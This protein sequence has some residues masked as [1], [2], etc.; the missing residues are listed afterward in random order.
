MATIQG[1]TEKT[2]FSEEE[3]ALLHDQD[4]HAGRIVGGLMSGVFLV[5]TLMYA[6]ICWLA[7]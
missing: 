4:I 3:E 5:G 1:T 6:Y 2:T 7:M